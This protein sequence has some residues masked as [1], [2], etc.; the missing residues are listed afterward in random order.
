MTSSILPVMV[1]DVV[2][3]YSSNDFYWKSSEYNDTLS[4]FP[5]CST[6]IIK[7]PNTTLINSDNS[8]DCYKKEVYNN[9]TKSA[10]LQEMQTSHSSSDG[11][12]KDTQNKFHYSILNTGN[13]GIGIVSILYVLYSL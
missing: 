7:Y 2:V 5:D 1:D 8:S 10:Y 6:D 13:L 3:A 12:Y 9:K 4:N 11:R